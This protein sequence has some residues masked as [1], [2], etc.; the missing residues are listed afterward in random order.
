MTEQLTSLSEN[1]Q[2]CTKKCWSILKELW[3]AIDEPT[4]S[5]KAQAIVLHYKGVYPLP[6]E[7]VKRYLNDIEH[8]WDNNPF[9]DNPGAD[10][11]RVR[12]IFMKNPVIAI[13]WK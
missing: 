12:E 10:L 1:L 8:A 13:R 5:G 6:E 3:R 9:P 11:R 2:H 7:T 4:L